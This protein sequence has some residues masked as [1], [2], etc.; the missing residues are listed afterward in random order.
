MSFMFGTAKVFA[1]FILLFV[2][3]YP[4][5]AQS[6]SIYRLPAG[7]HIRVRMDSEIG[8]KFSS[9]NDT[10]LTRVAMPV[11]VRDVTVLPVG[12]VVEGRILKV[13][14]A[15]LG[16]KSGLLEVR[17]ETLRFADDVS[18][19]IDG[20][21]TAPFKAGRPNGIWSIVGGTAIGAA[22]GFATGSAQ[23][24]LIGTGLGAGIGTGVAY[25]RKGHD[26]L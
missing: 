17:M 4:I 14:A 22:I 6:D 26:V 18:R 2:I 1:L 9:A 10:F 15:G 25:I 7:T 19:E 24:V 8:S 23:G 12:I 20:V 3:T 5:A 21:P 13:S 11:V 16:T